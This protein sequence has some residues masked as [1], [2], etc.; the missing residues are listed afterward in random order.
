MMRQRIMHKFKYHVDNF[1]EN[2]CVGC[3]RCIRECPVSL[4]IR[5]IIEEI[6]SAETK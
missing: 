4:D 5:E 3:G 1:G 2:F 6:C